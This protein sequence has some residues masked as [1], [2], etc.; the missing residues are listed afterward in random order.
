MGQRSGWRATDIQAWK[1]PGNGRSG[2]EKGGVAW[3]RRRPHLER[4][5]AF[6]TW[7]GSLW[8]PLKFPRKE[9][10]R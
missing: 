9:C 3:C 1:R 8:K 2:R 7:S 4:N 5:V 10:W 6:I